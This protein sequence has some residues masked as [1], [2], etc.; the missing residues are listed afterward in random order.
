MSR[1]AQRFGAWLD[2]AT[3]LPVVFQDERYTSHDAAEMLGGV[4]L[5]R[6]AKKSMS[7]AVAAQV[8]LRS[9]MEAQQTTA[10]Q[11]HPLRLVVG[12]GY[13]G[14]RVARRFVARGDRVV[15]TTRS[16]AR[17]AQ[18]EAAGMEAAIIDVTAADPGWSKLLASG[19]RPATIV[20]S[21]SV[22]RATAASYR[23]VHV[24]GLMKL[25]DAVQAAGAPAPRIVFA[26]STGVWGD[27]QGGTVTEATPATPSR[28]AGRV[29]LEA[30]QVLAALPA[31]PGTS[32]RFAGLYGP[33]RLPRLGDLRAGRPIAADPH[34]WLNLIHIDDAAAV[35]VAVADAA[36]PK[37]L[38][39]V[40]DGRP[41]LR[42]D[43][44]E[45]VAELAAAPMPTWDVAA[46]RARGGDKRVDPSLVMA[47]LGIELA[48]PDA[49]E[50]LPELLERPVTE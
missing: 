5:S 46:P 28:E 12:C 30:E 47:D 42:R 50:A 23:D 48:Y 18:L 35:V 45:R 22:D 1:E 27:E 14:E 41:V 6:G 25:L 40:S 3:G 10:K 49:L 16:P 24:G 20:W 36:S 8:I 33:G 32:L 9:W 39:V 11:P 34:A 21:V 43:W 44:Y 29:L 26:S 31:V 17:A 15:G 4:G 13:L 19:V 37:P 2:R 7:D 38:Y